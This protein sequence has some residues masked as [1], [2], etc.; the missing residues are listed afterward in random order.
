MGDEF[1]ERSAA[2]QV[3]RG[4]GGAPNAPGSQLS[5][6]VIPLGYA[7]KP[8]VFEPIFVKVSAKCWPFP[9]ASAPMQ[10]I[11]HFAAIF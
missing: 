7:L 2:I 10:L 8:V 6:R 11:I 5:S 3:L 9:A 4:L 1:S